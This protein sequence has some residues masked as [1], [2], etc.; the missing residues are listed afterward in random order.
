VV[1]QLAQH[2]DADPGIGVALRVGVPVGVENDLDLVELGPPLG[3]L[4][5]GGSNWEP[6]Q[7]RPR[8]RTDVG[9]GRRAA[10]AANR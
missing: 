3:A 8:V 10:V 9:D 4:L 1:H 7:M 5:A 6:G 2:V